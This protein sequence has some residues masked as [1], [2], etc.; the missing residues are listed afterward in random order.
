MPWSTEACGPPMIVILPRSLAYFAQAIARRMFGVRAPNPMM[1]LR[2]ITSRMYESL[3]IR[4]SQSSTGKPA[5]S[6][7]APM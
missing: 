4:S 6:M 2:S 3:Q 7:A 5:F 1:S